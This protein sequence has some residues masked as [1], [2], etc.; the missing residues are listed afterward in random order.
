MTLF[1]EMIMPFEKYEVENLQRLQKLFKYFS[2]QTILHFYY[3]K[4]K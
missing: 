1:P 3:A 2:L 4:K